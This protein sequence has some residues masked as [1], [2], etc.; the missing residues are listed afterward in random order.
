M[1]IEA[2]ILKYSYWEHFKRAKELSLVLPLN[3]PERVAIEKEM[4]VMTKALKLI[5]KNK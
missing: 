5:T 1:T 2:E 3:H 4:N